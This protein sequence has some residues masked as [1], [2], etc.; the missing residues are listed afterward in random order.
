MVCSTSNSLPPALTS[1]DFPTPVLLYS[2][3]R[4][5]LFPTYSHP[6]PFLNPLLGPTDPQPCLW[7]TAIPSDSYCTSGLR[8]PPG[9]PVSPTPPGLGLGPGQYALAGRVDI[10]DLLARAF[11]SE[12][13]NHL[14]LSIL[15]PL[16]SYRFLLFSINPQSYR[17]FHCY[18]LFHWFFQKSK[19][20][21]FSP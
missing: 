17:H 9:I 15:F 11:L 21:F 20:V 19:L 6:I 7:L 5:S 18:S 16:I 14:F 13:I 8:P 2:K 3:E 10:D 12:N 1:I 4:L